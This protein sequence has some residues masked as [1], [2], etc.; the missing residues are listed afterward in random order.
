MTEFRAAADSCAKLPENLSRVRER[1]GALLI[2][3]MRMQHG[4]TRGA[5]YRKY[6]RRADVAKYIRRDAGNNDAR[7]S[8][9]S[10]A[11]YYLQV[12]VFM[13]KKKHLHR[14]GFNEIQPK[15]TFSLLFLIAHG[16]KTVAAV[17][18]NL[19]LLCISRIIV[20]KVCCILS[21][22]FYFI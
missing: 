3:R 22:R 21:L 17:T 18:A 16:K 2:A 13:K 1:F 9:T 8:I 5:G 6:F 19:S 7:Y 14:R 15:I 11:V 20:E 10:T 4:G 12:L